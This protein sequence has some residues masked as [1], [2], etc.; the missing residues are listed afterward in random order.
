RVRQHTD[1][2]INN[3]IQAEIE[4]SVREYSKKNVKEI[5]SRIEQLEK[6]WDIERVL[7]TNAS[8][9]A[10]TGTALGAFVNRRWLILPGVVTSFLLQHAVQGWCPPLPVFR[11][12]G[13]RTKSEIDREKYALKLLRGDFD[14]GQG[15][16]SGQRCEK[17]LEYI[18][19]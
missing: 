13:I 11:R 9:L 12:L 15:L 1:S 18:R 2:N 4:K 10:L 5:T 3:K 17:A 19:T 16:K 14:I 8:I 7:E 6:E